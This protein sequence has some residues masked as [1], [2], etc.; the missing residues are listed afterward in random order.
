MFK[1]IVY[2]VNVENVLKQKYFFVI[3]RDVLINIR[4]N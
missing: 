2:I 4:I 3:S 1:G